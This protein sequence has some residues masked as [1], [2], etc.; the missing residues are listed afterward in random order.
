MHFHAGAWE[1]ELLGMAIM[2]RFVCMI[3]VVESA[4][5]EKLETNNRA[6]ENPG[7]KL[8]DITFFIIKT[9]KILKF[10]IA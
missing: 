5:V 10:I 7:I 3:C 8:R 4:R 6:P 9:L 1:R 2:V